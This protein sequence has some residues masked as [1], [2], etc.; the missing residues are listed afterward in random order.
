MKIKYSILYQIKEI[1]IKKRL[2]IK[3]HIEIQ[4]LLKIKMIFSNQTF[5]IIIV[6]S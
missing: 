5:W 4:D 1:K 3:A 2:I 6:F